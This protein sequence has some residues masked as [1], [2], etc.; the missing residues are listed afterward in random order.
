MA[1]HYGN[2]TPAIYEFLDANKCPD[3]D[4]VVL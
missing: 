4:G 1:S 2:T 3:T